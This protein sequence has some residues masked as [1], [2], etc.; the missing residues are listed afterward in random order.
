MP[1]ELKKLE[2]FY[3]QVKKL[4]KT[5]EYNLV[6]HKHLGDIFYAV[7][8]REE[9]ER[10]TGRKLHFIVRPD[11][12]FLLRMLGAT[13]YS[14][15]AFQ[16]ME[17]IA[18][19]AEY[20]WLPPAAH[21]S[22]RFDVIVKDVFLS[23]PVLGEPFILDGEQVH[24]YLFGC[25][26]CRL[27]SNNLLGRT[28]FQ[29][30]V[31]RG[32]VPMSSEGEKILSSL[33]PS[34]KII[35]LAPDAATATELPVEIWDALAEE[36]SKKGYTA[37]VNSKKYHIKHTTSA[38]DL[39]LSLPDVIAL[40]QRCA[41]VF[42]LRSG[43]CDVLVGIGKR[44][45]AIYPAMLRREFGSLIKPFAEPTEVNEIQFYH[46][47]TSPII[48]EGEDLTPCV[49]KEL[50]KLK[51]MYRRE[52]SLLTFSN[53]KKKPGHQFWSGVFNSV[54][55][56][57]HQFPENNV[58][59]PPLKGREKEV[60]VLG[61]TVYKRKI[62][63]R[64]GMILETLLGGLWHERRVGRKNKKICVCGVQV[65]SRNKRRKKV[66]WVTLE[67]YDYERQWLHRLAQQVGE[68]N[69]DVYLLRHNI[70]E[71]YV[72][73]VC[74]EE[75]I[76]MRGSKR[77]L[78]V[79]REKKYEEMCRM[80]LPEWIEVRH[81]P[82]E[83]GDIHWIFR[84]QGEEYRDVMIETEG[85][86]FFCSTPHVAEHMVEQLEKDPGVNFYRYIC[87]SV[88]V[89]P[90]KTRL[91]APRVLEESEERAR[92]MMEREG[93]EEGRYVVLL[94]EA[95]ST[96][97]LEDGFWQGLANELRCR[98]Y[99]VYVNRTSG[100]AEDTT[101][102]VLMEL[103][104]HAGGVIT[105]GS[106]IAIMLAQVATRLD[107]VYTPLKSRTI[108]RDA[109]IVM[110]LYSVGHLPGLDMQRVGEYDSGKL[111]TE[112]LTEQILIHYKRIANF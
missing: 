106:G 37:I 23:I 58:E 53:K 50:D 14:V 82:L 71:T 108:K 65:Y 20:P 11:H 55:G 62:E 13:N 85:H 66:L 57:S 32:E 41:Y 36:F 81:I 86:R 16:W 5:D 84:E 31:P 98:G 77:P 110:R 24:F 95:M 10:H 93:L 64:S 79:A 2:K 22:H 70:G 92:R 104:R 59:N 29:Y 75:R 7:S 25:Y 109:S 17:R 38:F 107:I 54:A 1:V 26:W 91:A 60:K 96:E 34:E 87:A 19:T 30:P 21:A 51:V 90:A 112:A 15:C 99:G 83:M 27:W 44:L 88:G 68:Q 52:R 103:C 101:V 39:G 100:D 73:L 47:R 9:F 102:G 97:E 12:V 6:L 3:E 35:L 33:A 61:I 89:E 42:S 49:Q 48:W 78:V 45:Y 43:L 28:D 72:E 18:R 63:A 111:S 69:D 94:P 80:L 40:G 56:E 74:M 67:R 8:L 76:R 4:C 105:L 46:W